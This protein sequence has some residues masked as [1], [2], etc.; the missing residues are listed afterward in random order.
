MGSPPFPGKGT[1]EL[2]RWVGPHGGL[3]LVKV[4]ATF[5]SIALQI[6]LEMCPIE[7]I[8]TRDQGNVTEKPVQLQKMALSLELNPDGRAGPARRSH[9]QSLPR[10]EGPESL[11]SLPLK[12]GP[13]GMC[14]LPSGWNP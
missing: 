10:L 13:Q 11:P 2:V 1:T 4:E 8:F 5:T 7:E 12:S 6:E 14:F 9:T 3:C